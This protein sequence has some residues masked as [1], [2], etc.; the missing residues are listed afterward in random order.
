MFATALVRIALVGGLAAAIMFGLA[1]CGGDDGDSLSIEAYL[2]EME[3]L[4][5]E[6]ET[7]QAA[8][9]QQFEA[10]TVGDS[11]SGP[12]TD[13]YIGALEAYYVGLV[14]AGKDFVNAVED[15]QPPDDAQDVHDEYIAAYDE[16]LA[17]LNIVIDGIPTL[18]NSGDRDA[19]LASPDLE[20]AFERGNAACADLQQLATDNNVSVDFGCQV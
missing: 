8:L 17:Q 19:L 14:E 9:R 15:L 4:D 6:A 1:A 16:L 11:G 7:Q 3:R 18:T 10:A 5:N 20:A 12:L 2:T 13:G